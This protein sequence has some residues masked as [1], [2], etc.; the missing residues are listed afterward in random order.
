MTGRFISK[1]ALKYISQ[2]NLYSIAFILES[3][4]PTGNLTVRHVK[5]NL[6]LKTPC[7][8]DRYGA[9]KFYIGGLASKL[10]PEGVYNGYIIQL[11]TVSCQVSEC[12]NGCCT[13]PGALQTTSY[14]EAWRV[15]GSQSEPDESWPVEKDSFHHHDMFNIPKRSGCGRV[16]VKGAAKFFCGEIP[17]NFKKPVT[18][19]VCGEPMYSGELNGVILGNDWPDFWLKPSVGV[20]GHHS[21]GREFEC[22]EGGRSRDYSYGGPL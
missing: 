5:N 9:W 19:D 13:V 1:D 14:F 11:V 20:V 8:G 18:I 16:H 10:C 21:L 7:E 2:Y 3:T 17:K 4:D 12:K 22:C 6:E 15:D